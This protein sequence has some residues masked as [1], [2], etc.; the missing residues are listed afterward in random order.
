M[1]KKKCHI[2]ERKCIYFNSNEV[3]DKYHFVLVCDF[4]TELKGN[5]ILG[6]NFMQDH[7]WQNGFTQFRLNINAKKTWEICARMFHYEGYLYH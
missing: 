4:Y 3:E 5:Y 7:V 6:N 2:Y 1:I